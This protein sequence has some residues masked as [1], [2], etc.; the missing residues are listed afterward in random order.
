MSPFQPNP[1]GKNPT[2]NDRSDAR[3]PIDLIDEAERF[4]ARNYAPLPVVLTRG[5]GVWVWDVEGK[6]YLDMLSAYSALNHGH[7]HP[8]VLEAAR[9]QMEALTLTSRAF[10]NDRMG[11]LLRDLCR[12]TGHEQALLM[13]TGAEAVETAIKM[14]R[15]WGYRKKGVPEGRAKIVACE[16]NFHGRTITIVGFSSERQYR[17]GFGPFTP[18]F[19]LV[20]YGDLDA[21]DGALDEQAV[22]F[23]VEPVQGEGGV[24]VPREGYLAGAYALCRERNVA[25]M[26][27]EIQT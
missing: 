4:G 11:P 1:A 6:R 7:R 5:A 18:G 20:P 12:A 22:G 19:E 23:L 24:V 10:H 14:V 9:A 25:F 26:A 27:D 21:L 16:N 17:R 13:N 15:K 3:A 8:A 2:A